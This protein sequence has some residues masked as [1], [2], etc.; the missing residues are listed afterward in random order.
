MNKAIDCRLAN[1]DTAISSGDGR[2]G[3]RMCPKRCVR[4]AEYEIKCDSVEL[5]IICGLEL[6]SHLAHWMGRT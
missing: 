2:M 3:G 4:S 5:N 6:K 1:F